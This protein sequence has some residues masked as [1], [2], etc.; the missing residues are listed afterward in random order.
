MIRTLLLLLLLTAPAAAHAQL[1]SVERRLVQTVEEETP[2]HVALLE[3]HVNQN[4]GTLNLAGVRAYADMLR[5]EFAAI[6]MEVRWVDM[7]ETGRAGHLIATRRSRG[8]NAGKH[9]L[10]IGHLDTV[11]ETDSPFQRFERQG[12]RAVGPG[13]ADMK[14]GNLVIL[15]ALR[16][17]HRARLLERMNVTVIFTGDEERTGGP[18]SVSRRDLVAAAQEADFALEFEGLARFDGQDMGTVARRGSTSWTLRTT[19]RTGHSSRVFSPE[20]GYGAIYEIARILDAFRRELPEQHLTLNTSLAA[21]GTPAMLDAAEVSA[22]ATGKTNVIAASAVARGDLRALTPEQ[23]ARIRA[24]MQEIVSQHLPLTSAEITFSDTSFPPMAPTDGNVALLARLNEVNRDL[25]L[26]AMQ[27][28]DP[29]RRGAADS[30]FA[31]P[32]ATHMRKANGRT[33]PASRSRPSAQ[34]S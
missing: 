21:G 20:L 24:R 4:S 8:R 30:G 28:A 16:A 26:P 13:V 5:P 23:E 18:L 3:R 29:D 32:Y 2:R 1:S 10:L 27:A 9:L 19:G 15:A 12:D 31:S 11:F 22:T 7:A 33:S 25:G 34:P 6:G 14:G 17:L